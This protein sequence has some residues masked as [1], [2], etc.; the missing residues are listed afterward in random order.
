[1]QNS[2]PK[3]SEIPVVGRFRNC[4]ALLERHPLSGKVLLDVGSSTGLLE[5]KLVNKSLKKIIG[6]EPNENAV[7]FA[8]RNVKGAEFYVGTADNLLVKDKSCDIVTMFDVI[9]HV[10]ENGERDAFTEAKRVLK[11]GGIFL[12]STPNDNFFTNFLDPAWYFGHRHYKPRRIKK[13]LV[14]SGF[15]ILN[16]EVRGGLWFS[17][18]LIWL[19]FVKKFYRN[20]FPRIRFLENL[21]DKEFSK[22][23]GIHTIFIVA[24]K[25]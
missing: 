1:M 19:Y 24:Y 13:L 12:L 14:D 15:K 9:E 11:K 21:D 23:N 8:K 18:Y 7:K 10:P 16:L 5:S 22:N 3:N 6:I 4:L 20:R 17:F 2:F 25:V